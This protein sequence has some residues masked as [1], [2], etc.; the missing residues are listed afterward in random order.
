LVGGQRERGINS[1]SSHDPAILTVGG[2]KAAL[3]DRSLREYNLIGNGR[4][5]N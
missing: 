2:H 5:T 4:H 3:F 1:N